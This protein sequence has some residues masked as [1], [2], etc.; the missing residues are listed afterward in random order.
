MGVGCSLEFLFAVPPRKLLPIDTCSEAEG[1][2]F[3]GLEPSALGRFVP[4]QNGFD[5]TVSKE[6]VR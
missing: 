1:H 6:S 2:L 3:N 4:F 5:L